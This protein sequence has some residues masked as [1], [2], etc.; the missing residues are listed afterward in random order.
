MIEIVYGKKWWN[1]KKRIID[2][3]SLEDAKKLH[4][5]RKDYTALIKE[6]DEIRY[7]I[8]FSSN[9]IIVRFF[10]GDMFL[11]YDFVT[12][13]RKLFLKAAYYYDYGPEGLETEMIYNFSEDGRLV[14]SKRDALSGMC[15]EREDVVDV[16]SNWDAYPKFGEYT[17]LLKIER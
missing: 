11:T 10:D 17:D 15:E 16:K 9:H 1:A 2:E 6:H 12:L 7:V 4:E 3:I 14:M 13:S 5:A 8:D